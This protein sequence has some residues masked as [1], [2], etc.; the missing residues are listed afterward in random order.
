VQTPGEI[1][2]ESV[3]CGDCELD[4]GSGAHR[5]RSCP[6]IVYRCARDQLLCRVGDAADHVWLVRHGAIGLTRSP[7]DESGRGFTGEVDSLR[8]PGGYVGL[9]CLLLD[10]Y[11]YS[12]RALSPS[13]VCRAS[14]EA[15]TAW[16][17]QSHERVAEVMRRVLEELVPEDV[18]PVSARG[19]RPEG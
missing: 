8:L 6:F 19:G 16:L 15:F 11:V 9:E 10:R 4:R 18:H 14:R 17:R 2:H 1:L 3:S 12:A 5:G 13:T 7:A